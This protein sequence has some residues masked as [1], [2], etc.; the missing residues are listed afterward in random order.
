MTL[1]DHAPAYRSTYCPEIR[2]TTAASTAAGML[3]SMLVVLAWGA[4]HANAAFA[5]TTGPA[6]AAVT[7]QPASLPPPTATGLLSRRRL[8]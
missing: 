8:K 1:T 5:D 6:A 2:P 7:A 4:W 3:L